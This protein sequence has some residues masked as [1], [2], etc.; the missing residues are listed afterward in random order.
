MNASERIET[1]PS[2]SLLFREMAGAPSVSGVF[3]VAKT[4]GRSAV[5]GQ[6]SELALAELSGICDA[7]ASMTADGLASQDHLVYE[8][9]F[10]EAVLAL[11]TVPLETLMLQLRALGVT[12]QEQVTPLD[13]LTL[14][15]RIRGLRGVADSAARLAAAAVL[16][17]GQLTATP[18]VASAA[19][20]ADRTDWAAASAPVVRV[21]DG[22]AGSVIAGVRIKTSDERVVGVTDE[23]GQ[24]TLGAGYRESDVLTLEKDGYELY[25]LEKSQLSGRNVIAMQEMRN[26]RGIAIKPVTPPIVHRTDNRVGVTPGAPLV[27]APKAPHLRTE[28]VVKKDPHTRVG[29]HATTVAAHNTVGHDVGVKAGEHVQTGDTRTLA[30]P[31]KPLRENAGVASVG[32]RF[33]LAGPPVGQRTPRLELPVKPAPSE[34]SVSRE[35]RKFSKLAVT[36]PVPP[37]VEKVRSARQ[38][39]YEGIKR[40]VEPAVLS[41][42]ARRLKL[43]NLDIPVTSQGADALTYR[44]RRGDTLGAIAQQVLGNAN[45]WPEIYALNRDRIARPALIMPGLQLRLQGSAGRVKVTNARYVVRSGDCLSVIAQRLLGSSTRWKALYQL[46]RGKVREPRLIFPGQ[47][48]IIPGG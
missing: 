47:V 5:L 16:A 46:N 37:G 7:L 18:M 17:V 11:E 8:M 20:A 27:L 13:A 29:V 42:P 43:S 31:V 45:R 23:N 14:R 30:L 21:V 12:A 6:H 3:S 44:V 28:G 26:P 19:S 35:G 38:A 33:P 9:L 10:L 24:A 39:H 48:L 32:E 2:Q 1:N 4:P 40:P 41:Q 36:L 22:R 25:L 15:D 34:A